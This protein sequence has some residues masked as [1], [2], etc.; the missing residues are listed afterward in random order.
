MKNSKQISLSTSERIL[1]AAGEVFAENGFRY[2][3]VRDIC[4][5]AGVNI[6]AV[7]YHFGDKERLY[8]SVLKYWRNVAFQK[9]PLDLRIDEHK[10]PEEHL[11]IFVR[12][13]LFRI[14]EEGRH[15][16]FGKLVAREFI[17]PTKALD[18]LIEE[19]IQPTFTFLSSV[20]Q[21][22]LEKSAS[23]E[24]IRFCCLSIVSQCLF[25]VYGKHIIKKLFHQ[26]NL[27]TEEIE[28]IADHITSFTLE[29]IKSLNRHV[30]GEG[31]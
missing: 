27:K 24:T 5:K 13:F 31:Q 10:K 2:A 16:W 22:M 21:Q 12:S 9:Y 19:T 17:E 18:V 3:T 4:E 29:G 20:V 11:R 28:S 15:S 26:D 23:E 6:A 25:F 1:E 8:Y 30:Q 14:L 7:N